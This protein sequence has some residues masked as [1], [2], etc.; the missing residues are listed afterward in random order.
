MT[1]INEV[2]L[3]KAIVHKVGNPTRNEELKLSTFPLTLNDELVKLLLTRYFLSSF[4]ENEHYHFT[5]ISDL[6]LNEVY[7]YVNELF[8]DPA[9]FTEQSQKIAG[10]LYSKSTH[11]RI[12]E[13]E[14]YI[15][16]FDE[17]PLDGKAHK[18]IGIFKS[19]NKETF[20][21]VFPHGQSWEV[22]PEEGIDINKLDK[23]C[24]IFNTNRED[25][26]I[27]CVVDKTNKQNDAQYW[28]ADFLQVRPLSDSYHHTD[29]A[30]GMCKLFISNEYADKFEIS[31]GDQVELMNRSMEYFKTKE[32]FNLQEFAEEV[33]HHPEVVNTFMGYK[34]QYEKSRNFEIEDSFDIHLSAVKKQERVFKSVIKLDKNFHLYIHGRRDLVEKGLDEHTGK[35]YYKLLYDEES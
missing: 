32:Q 16:L 8:N 12:K 10:F 5:H 15:A 18:A 33:M 20:L 31:K 3:Q 34:Q 7:T 24:L 11:A 2:D 13:G 21:K 27:V 25:G 29:Q 9:S 17:V 4:N 23:G 22:M 30:L 14:L 28:V 1:G 26:Y 35:K 19:E 6:A